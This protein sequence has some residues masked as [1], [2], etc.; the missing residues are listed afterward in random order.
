MASIRA[1]YFELS[2]IELMGDAVT[3]MANT[4]DE[5]DDKTD[6]LL[7]I[8]SVLDQ[9]VQNAKTM[10]YKTHGDIRDIKPAEVCLT[11]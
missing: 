9:F 5:V 11:L 8:G 1:V 4:Q 6:K 2:E 10:H 7:E 3:L